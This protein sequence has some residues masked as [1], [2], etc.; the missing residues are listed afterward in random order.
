MKSF[1]GRLVA[2][3]MI[4]IYMAVRPLFYPEDFSEDSLKKV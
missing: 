4:L 3:A 1:M 2:A